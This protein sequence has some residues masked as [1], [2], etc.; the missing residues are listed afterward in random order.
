MAC[1][2]ESFLQVV[3]LLR[4]NMIKTLAVGCFFLLF[5]CSED[6]Q[7]PEVNDSSSSNISNGASSGT[8]LSSGSLS[9][10]SSSNQGTSS[11]QVGSSSSAI[12]PSDSTPTWVGQSALIIT[13]I[14]PINYIWFDETG[15]DPGWVEIYNAGSVTANLNGYSLVENL[16][17]PR[18]WI[19]GDE[20]IGPKQF[21]TVFCDKKDLRVAPEGDDTDKLHFRTHTNWKLEKDSGT[22]Y[23]IDYNWNIRDSVKYPTLDPGVSWG[24]VDGGGW[25]YFAK[26][27]PE[28][29]NTES[30][31]YVDISE[32]VI[33]GDHQAGFYSEAISLNPPTSPDGAS[34]RCTFDGS[35]PDKNTPV[36]STAKTLDSTTVVRCG[37]FKDGLL[38]KKIVT[39][40]Y[41][42][43][44]SIAMPIISIAVDPYD[45]FDSANGY[46]SQGIA[47]CAEPC[48][49]ANYWQDIELPI[50]VEYF[51]TSNVGAPR[52]WNIEAGFSIMGGW[53]RYNEKKS[54]AISMREQY[55]DGRLQYPLFE[56]RPENSKF[57]GFNLRNNGN[58]FYFD[59]VEDAM[60][61]AL[62]EG[63][64][65]DYQRS[66]QVI[67][68]Y[69]GEYWGI[70]DMRERINEHYVETNYG[71][72]ASTVDAV[73]HINRLV[74]ANG[75][76]IDGYVAMLD[77]V[78]ANDFSEAGSAAYETIRA[79]VDVGSYADYM[80]AQ[81]FYQ[82]GDWP[83]NNVRAWRSAPEHPWK[84]VVF[85]LDHG[86]NFEWAVSGFGP[87][88][89]MFDWIE[90]GGK[91]NCANAG[92]F[93]QIYNKLIKNPDFKRLFIHRSA[94]M[95]KN[96]VTSARVDSITDAMVS[97]IPETERDRDLERWPR[98][99]GNFSY[100][101]SKLK[102]FGQQ[103]EGIVWD[104]YRSE[105]DLSSDVTVSIQSTGDGIV[106]MEGMTLPPRNAT[107][108]NY[109]GTFFGG[110]D[111]QLTA[112]PTQAGATFIKW[113]DGTTA[114][115]RLVTPTEG[116]TYIATFK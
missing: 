17:E 67:V 61:G 1:G 59:Y 75:G 90:Q 87:W 34:V 109:T 97:K 114:N 77:F 20:T 110:I 40:T 33:F 29:K 89:N 88:V 106:L 73:K 64:G 48:F 115:P 24:R 82:N 80:A 108:T 9:N 32:P 83:N 10:S 2:C 23:L 41:F 113:E 78:N 26:P 104:E 116:A 58:R 63:S 14:N 35:L 43:K 46:Y 81:I 100:S 71:I 55:Q 103:R 98:Y 27:T 60:G 37:A 21:R 111:M 49:D 36:F 6:P 85:D 79:M 105:F 50:H 95:L 7:K 16:A 4:S 5:G 66:R 25:K 18:K 47:S 56:T 12:V 62:L 70:H 91:D 22:V 102:E 72:D 76:T 57:K 54:V 101:G 68:F 45:M 13:E 19:F 69:N 86:F 3:I 93:A 52:A 99:K 15:A 74:T 51:E 107:K 8:P 28:K 96:Y 84:F 11:G 112:I 94:V 42:I 92:C 44:E 31:S 39:N 65:V 53:S 38:T 30:D